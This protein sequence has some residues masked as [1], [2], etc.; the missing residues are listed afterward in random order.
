M[1]TPTSEPTRVCERCGKQGAGVHTCTPYAVQVAELRTAL[2]NAEREREERSRKVKEWEAYKDK[3][4]ALQHSQPNVQAV[5]DALTL[6]LSWRSSAD[7]VW[8][9]WDQ[10]VYDNLTKLRD[11]LALHA[12]AQCAM[13]ADK[14]LRANNHAGEVEAERDA[15]QRTVA[16]M[17]ELLREVGNSGV[18]GDYRKYLVV[19]IDPETWQAV[20]AHALTTLTSEGSTD[21]R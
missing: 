14:Y 19:Q 20:R 9:E 21:A 5:N 12:D 6:M 2:A 13:Y 8:S 7:T 15:L 18:E 10:F 3:L 4:D 17:R 11:T 16:G 1:T